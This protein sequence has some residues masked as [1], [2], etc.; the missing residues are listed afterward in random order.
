YYRLAVMTISLPPLRD[1]RE[2]IPLLADHVIRQLAK[3]HGW[4]ALTL[5]PAAVAELSRRPW[6]GNVRELRN[7]LAR[8]ALLARGRTIQPA[9]LDTADASIPSANRALE[10]PLNL[11][12]AVAEVERRVI[13]QALEQSKWN[14][15]HAA[16]LLGISRR[17][18]FDKI[19]AYGLHEHPDEAG[20]S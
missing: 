7:A 5:S 18:L 3:T 2:D 14:R 13:G 9:D 16:R 1:R 20:Q 11:R 8:A 12:A 4:P 15:T 17:Q 10:N 19:Q 6:P